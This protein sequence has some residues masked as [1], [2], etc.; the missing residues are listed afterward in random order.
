M[1]KLQRI[2]LLKDLAQQAIDRGATSVEQIH[3]YIADLP[4]EMLEKGGLLRDDKLKLREKQR[5]TIGMV[6]DAIRSINRQIGQLI[7]DQFE[8]AE[9]GEHIAKTL[10]E[11][12]PAAK[13]AAPKPARKPAAKK[14]AATKRK[15]KKMTSQ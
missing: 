10:R 3:Q 4:F 15:A 6:Y 13:P 12:E 5:R 11:A 1:N 9:D 2:E 14:K 7:S 8:L